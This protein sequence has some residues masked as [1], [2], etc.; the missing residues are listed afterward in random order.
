MSAD[1]RKIPPDIIGIARAGILRCR[2]ELP[3]ES[4]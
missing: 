3:E 2:D 1:V 4:P